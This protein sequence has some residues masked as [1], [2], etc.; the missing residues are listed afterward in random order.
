MEDGTLDHRSSLPLQWR[1]PHGM[2]KLIWHANSLDLNPIETLWKIIK[3]LLQHH[4]RPKNKEKMAQT[5]QSRWDTRI[6][7]ATPNFN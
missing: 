6:F 2:A 7:G 3:N 5:I 1:Q 4:P